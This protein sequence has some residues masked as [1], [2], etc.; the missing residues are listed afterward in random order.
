ML[1]GADIIAKHERN[2]GEH[3]RI[4]DPEHRR[5]LLEQKRAGRIPKLRDRLLAQVPASTRVARDGS[6]SAAM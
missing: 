4:E 1:D 5:E 6:T 2:R 3:Q